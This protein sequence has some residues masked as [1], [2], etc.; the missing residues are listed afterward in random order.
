MSCQDLSIAGHHFNDDLHCFTF[1]QRNNPWVGAWVQKVPHSGAHPSSS[2][3]PLSSLY[4]FFGKLLSS[5]FP[6]DPPQWCDISSWNP[7]PITVALYYVWNFEIWML[8]WWIEW[9]QTSRSSIKEARGEYISKK[10]GETGF[11]W[12]LWASLKPF[13]CDPKY[14]TITMKCDCHQAAFVSFISQ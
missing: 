13:L 10:T 5:V 11:L 12:G 1:S 7:R 14:V 6:P 3:S 9:N 2:S 8:M 4:N